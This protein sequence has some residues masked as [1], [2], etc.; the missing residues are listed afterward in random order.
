M[1]SSHPSPLQ[2][3]EIGCRLHVH[4]TP[5]A[6]RD[7]VGGEHDGALRVSVTAPADKGRANKAISKLLAKA[8]GI[9]PADIE[10]ASGPTNRRKTFLI[11]VSI[12]QISPHVDLLVQSS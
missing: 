4:A 12:E 6:R 3:A 9:K 11:N 7:H 2:S 1:V 5:G 10:L 8:L